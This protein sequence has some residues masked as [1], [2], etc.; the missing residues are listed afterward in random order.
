VSVNERLEIGRQA[1]ELRDLLQR[2]LT[3]YREQSVAL[4]EAERVY[5]QAKAKA[6]TVRAGVGLAAERAAQVDADTSD[7]R[8]ARDL[9]DAQAKSARLA[10]QVRLA[11]LDFLRSEFSAL[12]EDMR[13]A[14]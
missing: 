13:L 12:R 8:Y 10:V 7:L 11:E 9:A 5:R 1:R 2:G 3:A 14:E 4:A 6:W